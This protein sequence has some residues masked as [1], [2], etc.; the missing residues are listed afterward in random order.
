MYVEG[1][2]A[3]DALHGAEA[4][5]SCPAARAAACDGGDMILAYAS[6]SVDGGS[7]S[8]SG[9][10]YIDIDDFTILKMRQQANAATAGGDAVAAFARPGLLVDAAGRVHGASENGFSMLRDGS[11]G[12]ALTAGAIRFEDQRL[13]RQWQGALAQVSQSH[14]ALTV[15]VS[16]RGRS[17]KIELLPWRMIG[18][19]AEALERPLL[20]VSIDVECPD[21]MGRVSAFALRHRLTTAETQILVLLSQGLAAKE[22]AARRHCSPHTVRAQLAAIMAKTGVHSQRQ[23]LAGLAR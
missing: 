12:I 19:A 3:N 2:S 17:C 6:D 10:D 9:N 20:L 8:G 15:A 23:L 22:I 7:S 1:T 18:A 14:L 13:Q 5:T 21:P 11:L 4:R 16:C